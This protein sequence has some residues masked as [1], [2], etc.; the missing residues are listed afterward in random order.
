MIRYVNH[1]FHPSHTVVAAVRLYNGLTITQEQVSLL[2]AQFNT[3]NPSIIPRIGS[4]AKI[5]LLDGI[6]PEANDN[7]EVK[8]FEG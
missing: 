4:V 7:W 2:L 1:Q 8:V 3:L 5:P 6:E